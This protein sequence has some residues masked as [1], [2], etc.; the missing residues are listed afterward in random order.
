MKNSPLIS[1]FGKFLLLTVSLIICLTALEFGAKHFLFNEDE[2]H[3]GVSKIWATYRNTFVWELGQ[4]NGCPYTEVIVPHPYLSHVF[5][6]DTTG[7]CKMTRINNK[8]MQDSRD[9][10]PYVN[11]EFYSILVV[12][13]SVA[14]Q[15]VSSLSDM[16]WIE[17]ELNKNYISPNG[18]PFRVLS[19]GG[20]GWKVPL[21][22][23]L[24]VLY[25]NKV[26]AVISVDGFNEASHVYDGRPIDIPT[27]EILIRVYNMDNFLVKN[28][29]DFLKV[30]RRWMAESSILQHSYLGFAIFRGIMNLIDTP[31]VSQERREIIDRHFK[32]PPEFTKEQ[33]DDWSRNEFIKYQRLMFAMAKELKIKYVHFLQ[34]IPAIDK[35]LTEEESSYADAIFPAALYK[36]VFMSAVSELQKNGYPSV[37]LVDVFKGNK[38]TLYGD[39]V[40]CKI[41]NGTESP[42]YAIMSKRITEEL[43]KLWKLKKKI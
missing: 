24:M 3:K 14:H 11:P 16:N 23:I 36:S 7:P 27:T 26:D 30:W 39:F 32:F 19:G 2:R 10:E 29:I 12:G 28:T 15:I 1:F 4:N 31:E 38:E 13:G 42:C 33:R 35:P 40:H 20:G 5:A 25:G 22:N 6:H 8:G 34:P 37:S 21:Q 41:V 9:I 43:A 17:E 18:K